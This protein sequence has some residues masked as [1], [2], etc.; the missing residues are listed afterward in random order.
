MNDIIKYENGAAIID[1]EVSAKIASFEFQMKTIK[2]YEDDLKAQILASMEEHEIKEID[3]EE[4][5]ITYIPKSDRESFDSKRFRKD[6]P[7]TYDDYVKI[8]SVKP[9]VRIKLKQDVK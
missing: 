3:T 7:D 2:K 4:I 8:S 9:S 5:A 1:P 6:H